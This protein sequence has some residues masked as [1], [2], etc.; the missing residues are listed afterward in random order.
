VSTPRPD[1][2]TDRLRA[3]E[4]R[5][6]AIEAE[7]RA[8]KSRL[9][10]QDIAE[11]IVGAHAGMRDVVERIDQVAPTDAPVLILGETGTGKEVVARTIHARSGRSRGPMVCVNCGAIAPGLVDSELFGHE[12]GS[13]TGAIAAKQG[14]FERADG[15][16][17]FLDEVGELKPTPPSVCRR[18]G[19]SSASG[20]SPAGPS[21]SSAS[22]GRSG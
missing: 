20:F 7:N 14:W 5:R 3:L 16:T 10:R 8:L 12:R 21:R 17:L 22:T 1:H 9:E 2:E 19:R 4:R 11:S 13:F 6:E 15:G 18:R